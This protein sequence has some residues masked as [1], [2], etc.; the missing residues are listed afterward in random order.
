M[1]TR[2]K[3]TSHSWRNWALLWGIIQPELCAESDPHFS[4]NHLGFSGHECQTQ[5]FPSAPTVRLAYTFPKPTRHV[6]NPIP[7]WPLQS[8]FN[9]NSKHS[10]TKLFFGVKRTPPN[11]S[12]SKPSPPAGVWLEKGKGRHKAQAMSKPLKFL[13]AKQTNGRKEGRQ[14][15]TLGPKGDIFLIYYLQYTD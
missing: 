8:L 10:K 4:T 11:T 12:A 2:C 5:S 6:S 7:V 13:L 3:N 15:Q 1:D 14:S 9:I